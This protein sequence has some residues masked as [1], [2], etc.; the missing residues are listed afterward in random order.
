MHWSL[1]VLM[2]AGCCFAWTFNLMRLSSA[3]FY[4][5]LRAHRS[6]VTEASGRLVDE[7]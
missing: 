7:E 2:R 3:P 1:R 5:C 4:E 6:A